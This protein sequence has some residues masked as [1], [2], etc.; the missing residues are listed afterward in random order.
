MTRYIVPMITYAANSVIK[1]NKSLAPI[2]SVNFHDFLDIMNEK[3]HIEEEH[4]D[5]CGIRMDKDINGQDVFRTAGIAQESFQRS[6]CLT[7]FHQVNMRLER[8]HIIKTKETDKKA[9]TNMKHNKL[10]Q[11]NKK[12]VEVICSKLLRNGIINGGTEVGEDLMKL[13]L[14]KILSELTDPQLEAFILA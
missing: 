9:T 10:V 1:I 2:P 14:M 8:L 5:V 12:V 3:G 13:C 11:A 7:H 4:F 6:K